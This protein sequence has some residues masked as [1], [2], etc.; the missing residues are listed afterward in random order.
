MT[1]N[2]L[3]ETFDRHLGYLL[4]DKKLA[5]GYVKSGQLTNDEYERLLSI[6][7][8]TTKKYVGWL[9]KQYIAGYKNIDSLRNT[10]QEYNVFV[11]KNKTKLTQINKFNNFDEL[12][13]EVDRV[14]NSGE[15]VSRKHLENQYDVIVDD[16]NMLVIRPNTHEASRK[17]GLT[18]FKF[19]DCEG[20]F[21][22]E[23]FD[24]AWCITY[25]AP[26][27]WDD[28]YFNQDITFYF[29][30]IRN[31]ELL[32]KLMTMFPTD[33]KGSRGRAMRICSICVTGS[34]DY[35]SDYKAKTYEGNEVEIYDGT[36]SVLTIEETT[37]YLI[38]IDFL[39][40]GVVIPHISSKD[41]NI[42]QIKS[43]TR[44][45]N[46]YIKNGS[47]GNFQYMTFD[48]E[49]VDAVKNITH[50]FGDLVLVGFSTSPSA[51]PPNLIRVDG[52]IDANGA[53]VVVIK[54]DLYVN[55]DLLIGNTFHLD[56]VGSNITV[57]NDCD[58][59]DSGVHTIGDNITI[60]GDFHA[61][62]CE[63]L[64][65]IGSKLSV[66]KSLLLNDCKIL[67]QLPLDI[68]V[69]HDVYVNGTP[70][71]DNYSAEELKRMYPGVKGQFVM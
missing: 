11:V 64:E 24:S 27:H 38:T 63:H 26:D 2:I 47:Q 16:A 55:G 65:S 39:K 8:T 43:R 50:I 10:I 4:E 30:L 53:E 61:N 3:N 37:L 23:P 48:E 36:D 49:N 54:S 12:K 42:E 31:E 34:T 29:V 71:A 33:E 67:E 5:L 20:G 68:K 7:P 51:L 45:I 60:G 59:S 17:L 66:G 58:I 62:D 1:R 40:S 56:E 6:D 14:N 44:F 22:K 70:L 41:R 46:N 21:E 19:R 28:Y 18:K 69:G 9:A 35:P 32:N 13:A 15:A 57:K 52:N 25:K